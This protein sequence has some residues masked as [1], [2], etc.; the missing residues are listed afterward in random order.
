MPDSSPLLS[1][2]MVSRG[3]FG[4]VP[5][6]T[7]LR[8]RLVRNLFETMPIAPQSRQVFGDLHRHVSF[9]KQLSLLE[10]DLFDDTV[11]VCQFWFHIDSTGTSQS[12]QVVE[13]A[14]GFGHAS[15]DMCGD[16]FEIE[17]FGFLRFQFA[18]AA[19]RKNSP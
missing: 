6:L 8:I 19:W 12:D 14:S 3:L 7:A 4:S 15:P 2:R 11:G 16:F 17:V 1:P 18:F 10:K 13:K 5:C 9:G